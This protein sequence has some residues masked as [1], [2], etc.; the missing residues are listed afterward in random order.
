[1]TEKIGAMV[2]PEHIGQNPQLAELSAV[3]A[4]S[5]RGTYLF[6]GRDAQGRPTSTDN[7]LGLTD[8]TRECY[9][10]GKRA[11]LDIP[12]IPYTDVTPVLF[13]YMA[14]KANYRGSSRSGRGPADL[15]QISVIDAKGS[16]QVITL[17]ETALLS[18]IVDSG[19]HIWENS[20]RP[21]QQERS[22]TTLA[23]YTT[24][25]ENPDDSRSAYA[26]LF[27][28][29]LAGE[30][31]QTTYSLFIQSVIKSLIEME[32]GQAQDDRKGFIAKAKQILDK[33]NVVQDESVLTQLLEGLGVIRDAQ[34][35]SGGLLSGMLVG[36]LTR[37]VPGQKQDPALMDSIDIQ[38][39][40]ATLTNNLP[41]LFRLAES[42]YDVVQ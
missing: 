42:F 1:M 31:N 32:A 19:Q 10:N 6:V 7:E 25:V 2:Q 18:G 3:L 5:R 29:P 12:R 23:M 16:S 21:G 27:Q 34:H 15:L 11:G 33:E 40:L 38:A 36:L 14:G 28:P 24:L 30:S 17:N 41:M 35:K 39:K 26:V 22:G 20:V 4:W 13:Q 8:D 37:D 9:R